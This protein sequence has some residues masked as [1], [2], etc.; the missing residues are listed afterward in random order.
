MNRL[1]GIFFQVLI[2][3]AANNEVFA[4]AFIPSSPPKKVETSVSRIKGL[5]D[6]RKICSGGNE[7]GKKS[8]RNLKAWAE[9]L[10]E[11]VTQAGAKTAP[12][13]WPMRHAAIVGW[14]ESQATA[15]DYCWQNGAPLQ[16]EVAFL[17]S[18]LPNLTGTICGFAI[19]SDGFFALCGCLR[20]YQSRA[21]K[22]EI[23]NTET[24]P[25]ALFHLH[26]HQLR[27]GVGI[28]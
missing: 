28:A 5:S 17:K 6:R 16:V 13:P 25:D 18:S 7:V 4:A 24:S 9:L 22:R 27:F 20:L 8:N 2:L 11:S 19:S 23:F 3:K 12:D 21:R 26:L 10:A 1:Q 15:N 14:P